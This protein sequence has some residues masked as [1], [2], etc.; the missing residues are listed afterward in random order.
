ME[1]NGSDVIVT[2]LSESVSTIEIEQRSFRLNEMKIK[3]VKDFAL[4]IAEIVAK[5]QKVAKS[6]GISKLDAQVLLTTHYDDAMVIVSDAVNFLFEYKNEKYEAVTPEW[7]GDNIAMREM[8][9]IIREVANQ[10]R[11]EWLLPFLKS[12]LLKAISDTVSQ[13]TEPEK[14]PQKVS[15]KKTPPPKN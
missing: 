3:R 10:N 9:I 11:F 13:E 1:P 7:V 15:A 4:M 5:I 14:P 2:K 12:N 6:E 8:M